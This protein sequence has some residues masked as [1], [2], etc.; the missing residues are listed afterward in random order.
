MSLL[1]IY[2]NIL[3]TPIKW[4]Y[5]SRMDLSGLDCNAQFLFENEDN[6]RR[7]IEHYFQAGNKLS[8]FSSTSSYGMENRWRHTLSVFLL[9]IALSDALG[10]I[11][12]EEDEHHNKPHLYHWFL[13]CLYHD[14]GYTIEGNSRKYPPSELSI[15]K[16]FKDKLDGKQ[17]LRLKQDNGEFSDTIRWKYYDF[18]RN[19]RGFINHGII[20][21]LMLYDQLSG[22]LDKVLHDH[23]GEK[24][25]TD[26]T[27]NLHYSISHKKDFALCADAIIAHNI[28]FNVSPIKELQLSGKDKHTY[29]NWLTALLVFCD[30]IE[31]LKA[32]PCCPPIS[33]LEY[34]DVN[35]SCG[36]LTIIGNNHMC[37][38]TAYIEKC[39]SLQ[40]WTYVASNNET[41]NS[42]ELNNIRNLYPLI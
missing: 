10:I 7:F 35:V 24:E 1:E 42:I 6:A 19:R 23:G 38:Y 26:A 30:T 17:Y 5:Y 14:Y 11:I 27:T 39:K 32:F 4:K 37:N 13:T 40:D 22:H 12:A 18:C 16:L 29:K 28:W 20:G 9:G 25:F 3:S 33:V 41:N 15:H 36:S 8:I 34:V 2:N 31:P 21:G